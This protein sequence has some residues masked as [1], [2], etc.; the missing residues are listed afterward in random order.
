MDVTTE[1]IEKFLATIRDERTKKPIGAVTKNGYRRY[2]GG[3]LAYAKRQKWLPDTDTAIE[4]MDAFKEK[5][6][7]MEIYTPEEMQALVK[8]AGREF[9]PFI[10]LIA[11]GGV[12][13]EELFKGLA[14][15]NI[16]FEESAIIVPNHIAKTGKKRKIGMPEN[17]K[18]ILE[19]YRDSKGPIFAKDPRKR[20]A[21]LSKDSKVAW[22]KNALRHSFGSYRT[23]QL[24]NLGQVALEMGN[25]AR[26]VQ[27]HYHD[28]VK[29]KEAE[30]YWG[31]RITEK[32]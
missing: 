29:A 3:M 23:E 5:H 30:K 15:E 25:S 20:M 21:K 13:R 6:R 7:R 27:E 10:A 32:V 12:R 22:K 31:I 4:R 11:F 9:L 24:K 2:I 16:D 1:G 8:H 19:P 14:W 26:I 17:L 28:V 18:K